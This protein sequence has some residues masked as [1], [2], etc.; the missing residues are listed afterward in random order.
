MAQLSAAPRDT[1][2]LAFMVREG[3]APRASLMMATSEGTRELPPTTSTEARLLGCS[4]A[5]ASACTPKAL[6]ECGG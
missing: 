6:F 5:V 2:S 4:L 1:H 3:S